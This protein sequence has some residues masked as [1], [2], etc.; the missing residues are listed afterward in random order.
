M[1][2]FP[3]DWGYYTLTFPVIRHE[4]LS[5]EGIIEEMASCNRRFYSMP[6]M[7]RRIFA[8]F[9]Q[10]RQPL[11][12]VVGNLSYRHNSALDGRVHASFQREQAGRQVPITQ[13]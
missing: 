12:S 9:L 1:K 2:R 4:Q 3:D 5:L 13:A 6:R 7:L 8:S 10:W 11:I